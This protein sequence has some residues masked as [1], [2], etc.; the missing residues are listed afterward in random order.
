M[1]PKYVFD[2]YG[3]SFWSTIFKVDLVVRAQFW[4]GVDACFPAYTP[5]LLIE[6]GFLGRTPTQSCLRL[7]RV[8][9]RKSVGN[10]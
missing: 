8:L 9:T 2:L 3:P 4:F 1:I 10:S 5:P 6:V 7:E